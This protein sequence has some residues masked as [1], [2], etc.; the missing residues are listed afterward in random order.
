MFL[1]K[2]DLVSVKIS[3][4][5]QNSE[6]I[7]GDDLIVVVDI[8]DGTTQKTTVSDLTSSLDT[9]VSAPNY[10]EGVYENSSASGTILLSPK[11]GSIQ[12]ISV[13]ATVV[14]DLASD[15]VSG[16]SCTLHIQNPSSNSISWTSGI[17]WIGG[18]APSLNDSNG[19]YMVS[20]WRVGSSYYGA[21]GGRAY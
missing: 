3:D 13:S 20:I 8:S 2:E 6:G 7:S 18:S 12:A 5:P 21:Y 15:F 10:Q 4:L 11:L 1:Y 9:P 16:E 19:T 17:L 14:F